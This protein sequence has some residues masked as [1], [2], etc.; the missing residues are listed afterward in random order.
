MSAEVV[1]LVP[2]RGAPTPTFRP[3]RIVSIAF[4]EYAPPGPRMLTLFGPPLGEAVA[5]ILA[6]LERGPADVTPKAM[7]LGDVAL[8][9]YRACEPRVPLAFIWEGLTE[10]ELTTTLQGDA[11]HGLES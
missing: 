6:R 4:S 9:S 7:R 2:S 10:A 11:S 3:G 1:A 8:I 5:A